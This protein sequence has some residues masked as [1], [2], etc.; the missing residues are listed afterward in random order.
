[1]RLVGAR[2]QTL[3]DYIYRADG[4]IT[5]GGTAQLV[6]P[7]TPSRSMVEFVNTSAGALMVCHGAGTAT[8]TI[9]GGKVTALAVVNG[10]FGFTIP[11][12]VE[13]LGGGS[14]GN[15]TY[16]GLGQPGAQAPSRPAK[17]RAV[18]SGGM[19]SS[20]LIDDP[21]AGYVIAPYVHIYNSDLDP[22]GAALPSATLGVQLFPGGSF[23]YNGTAC[24]TEPISVWGA[25]TGQ[26]FTCGWMD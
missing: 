9:S 13:L 4:S 20:F 8:A 2:K 24:H 1:V 26:T 18:L 22:Y 10:G 11:P 3:R 15:G 23:T 7:V 19:I 14:A 6:L 5:T 16:L 17:V 12:V 21:G 25:T